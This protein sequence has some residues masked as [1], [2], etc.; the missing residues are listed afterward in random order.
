MNLDHTLP[1]GSC[2]GCGLPL[3]VQAEEPEDGI[4]LQPTVVLHELPICTQYENTSA[5]TFLRWVMDV[6]DVQRTTQGDA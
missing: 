5:D 2:P 1:F 4:G 6:R 3:R